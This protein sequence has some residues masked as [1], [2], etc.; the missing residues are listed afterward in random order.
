MNSANTRI[1]FANGALSCE[2]LHVARDEGTGT[3]SFTYDFKKNEVRI[4]N[5]KSSLN[6]AEAIFWIDPKVS[7]TVAPYIF[8]R[9]PNVSADG[10]YQFRGGKNTRLEIKVDGANGMDYVFLGKTLEF[11]RVSGRLLFTNDRL[12]ITDI[13]GA[14]LAGALRGN[15]DISLARNDPRYRAGISVSQINFPLLT[16]LYYNYKTAQGV[17]KGTYNFTGLGTDWRTMRGDGKA[18]ITNEDIC[19]IPI[20]GALLGI[21]HKILTGRCHSIACTGTP[22]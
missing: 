3:G 8:R 6:P 14:L 4:S 5:I 20:I 9:P 16:D 10:V 2:D 1:H 18:E 17:L 19:G 22:A 11:D 21:L 12:Q 13:R 15:A 7:K